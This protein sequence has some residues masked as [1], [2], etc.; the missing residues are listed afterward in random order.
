V[1]NL[2]PKELG[3]INQFRLEQHALEHAS[4][5]VSKFDADV[6][7]CIFGS[8]RTTID[9]RKAIDDGSLLTDS[10]NRN[11]LDNMDLSE[12][13]CAGPEFVVR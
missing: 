8:I 6:W 5:R 10:R 12:I 2:L 13:L 1:R 4:W 11:L 7:E 3:F 9:F